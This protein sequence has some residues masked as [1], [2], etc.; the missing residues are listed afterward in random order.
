MKGKGPSE[1]GGC[2]YNGDLTGEQAGRVVQVRSDLLC[3]LRH[4]D[5]C[6]QRR[7]QKVGWTEVSTLLH[8]RRERDSAAATE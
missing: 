8:E 2:T 3:S 7:E 6:L 5:V 1:P 4:V